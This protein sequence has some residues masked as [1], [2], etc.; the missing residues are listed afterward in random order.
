K[1]ALAVRGKRVALTALVAA[2]AAAGAAY[3]QMSMA[4]AA[5]SR[6]NSFRELGTSYKNFNDQLKRSTPIKIMMSVSAKEIVT[7]SK[8]QYSWFPRGSGTEAAPKTRAKP[9]I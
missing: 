9:E 2:V 4:D 7:A 3:A 5:K 1:R 6:L 8:N